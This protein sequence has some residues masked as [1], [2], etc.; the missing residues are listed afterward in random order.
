MTTISNK[1]YDKEL[2]AKGYVDSGLSGSRGDY[3]INSYRPGAKK[4]HKLPAGRVEIHIWREMFEIHTGY[5]KFIGDNALSATLEAL[6]V[7]I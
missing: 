4:K 6:K 7:T 1:D 3:F 5:G 2:R